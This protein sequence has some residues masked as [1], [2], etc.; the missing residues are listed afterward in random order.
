[1]IFRVTILLLAVVI[2]APD[3]VARQG[4]ESSDGAA[5]SKIV[6]ETDRDGDHEIYVMNADG[7]NQVN[8]TNNPALDAAPVWSPDGSKNELFR[9]SWISDV[10]A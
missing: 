7:S 2:T 4:E 10:V 1:M 5:M 8:L 3:A 9:R 6:F